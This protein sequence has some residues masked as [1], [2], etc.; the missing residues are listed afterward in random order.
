MRGPELDI[1]FIIR[2]VNAGKALEVGGIPELFRQ[3]PHF[4]RIISKK[5]R[6]AFL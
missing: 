3:I 6:A 4:L 1:I 5:G 2:H